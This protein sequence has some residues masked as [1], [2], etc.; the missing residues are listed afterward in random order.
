MEHVAERGRRL[1]VEFTC[2][3]CGAKAFE[4]YA[5]SPHYNEVNNMRSVPVPKGWRDA[6]GSMPLLCEQ[7]HAELDAFMQSKRTIV[8]RDIKGKEMLDNAC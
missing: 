2:G 5:G 1:L 3:R 8:G 6:S 4:P 7:C